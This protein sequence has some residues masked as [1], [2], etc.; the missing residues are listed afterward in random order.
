MSSRDIHNRLD[1]LADDIGR[2]RRCVDP[3]SSL[4]YTVDRIAGHIG[5]IHLIVHPS[6]GEL[7]AQT[8]PGDPAAIDEAIRLVDEHW[9]RLQRR[10]AA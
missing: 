7:A 5:A 10:M 6:A 1:L 3:E 2:L 4:G 9:T 8:A